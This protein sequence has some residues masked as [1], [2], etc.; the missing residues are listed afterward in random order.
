MFKYCLTIIG[1]MLPLTVL[2]DWRDPTTPGNLPAAS[3]AIIPNGETALTLSAILMTESGRYATINGKTVKAG[4]ILDNATRLLKIMPNY[5][6]I[7]Q[8]DTTKKLYLVPL[9]KNR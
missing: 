9:L 6:L 8:H 4:A 1:L 5:V 7:R 2:S 3:Q